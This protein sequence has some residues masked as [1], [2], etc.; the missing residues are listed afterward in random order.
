MKRRATPL[1]QL[2]LPFGEDDIRQNNKLRG[3]YRDQ[4]A[5][6]A[7]V[8]RISKLRISFVEMK[9]GR[10]VTTSL[11]DSKFFGWRGFERVEYPLECAVE[12]FLNHSGGVSPAARRALSSVLNHRS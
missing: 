1:E 10:L 12:N 8:Y 3:V 11:P 9:K 5:R 6:H 2:R 7:I 4:H